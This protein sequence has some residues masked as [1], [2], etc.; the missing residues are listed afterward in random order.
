MISNTRNIRRCPLNNS[1]QGFKISTTATSHTA[2]NPCHLKGGKYLGSLLIQVKGTTR[3]HKHT[4]VGLRNYRRSQQVAVWVL[5]QVLKLLPLLLKQ[6]LPV[7][8]ATCPLWDPWALLGSQD[9][10]L[11]EVHLHNRLVKQVQVQA[12]AQVHLPKGWGEAHRWV[13]ERPWVAAHPRAWDEGLCLPALWEEV[14]HL[15][16]EVQT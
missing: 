7:T 14:K 15:P 2:K 1:N 16:Q 3:K 5:D 9:L 13:V 8:L 12:L 11:R 4:L 6:T 10:N